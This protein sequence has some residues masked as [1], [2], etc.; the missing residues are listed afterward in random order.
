[1]INSLKIRNFQS[2]EETNLKFSPGVNVIV[3]PSDC[4]KTAI[5][6][7]FYW[8]TH[9][10]PS[11]DAFR[12][13]GTKETSVVL[14]TNEG[15]SITRKKSKSKNLYVLSSPGGKDLEFTAFGQSVP[16]EIL[17]TLNLAALNFQGQHDP[18]FL[19][20]SSPGEVARHLNNLVN[21]DVIDSSQK[22]I[23]RRMRRFQVAVSTGK[24]RITGIKNEIK[25]YDYLP[26]MER[27]ITALEGCQKTLENLKARKNKLKILVR[28]AYDATRELSEF[29]ESQKSLKKIEPCIINILRAREHRTN[30]QE[31]AEQLEDTL[32]KYKKTIRSLE[33][34]E[35]KNKKLL[36][37]FKKDMPDICPLC[38]QEIF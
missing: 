35:E 19:L 22:N 1:M 16:E 20:S 37:K 32:D 10:R 23:N 11:G 31:Q 36:D 18:P 4:G 27:R 12:R 38:G 34:A 17:Q 29:Q 2:H 9:N 8:N 21:I 3:G 26:E 7:S 15:F 33:K 28:K 6:R 25:E 14:Q 30:I 5:L 13:K 24:E